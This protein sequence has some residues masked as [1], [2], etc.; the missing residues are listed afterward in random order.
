MVTVIVLFEFSADFIVCHSPGGGKFMQFGFQV[1]VNLPFA[2]SAD[3]NVFVP[4]GNVIQI[5]QVA[6]YAD[7]AEFGYACQQSELDITVFRLE[8]SIKRFQGIAEL[9]LQFFVPD[10][11]QHGFVILIHEDNY[12]LS[13]LL[14]GSL[15]DA[16]KTQ[17]EGSL[18]RSGAIQTFPIGQIIIQDFLQALQIV[19]LLY[20]EVQVQYGVRYPI[21]FQLFHGQ[22]VEQLL[23]SLEVGFQRGDEQAL[24]KTAR[25]TQKII[26]ASLHHFMHQGR[27][28]NVEITV[29][30][31]FLE[32]LDADG[33]NLIAHILLLL[34]I[35]TQKY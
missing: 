22:S 26:T 12:A 9:L 13:R 19:I 25:T 29:L 18:G 27:L 3:L 7:F 21:L 35:N 14:T 33:K 6:E 31:N 17:G 1:L 20:V 23:L 8:C 32:I 5:I 28:I 10:S 15:N 34:Y 2:D 11:L 16:G 24:A 4:H 30:T